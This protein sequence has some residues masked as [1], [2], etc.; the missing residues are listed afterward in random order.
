MPYFWAALELPQNFLPPIQPVNVW[1]TS[2]NEEKQF[3]Q[4]NACGGASEV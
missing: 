4:E 1:H 3:P 2:W